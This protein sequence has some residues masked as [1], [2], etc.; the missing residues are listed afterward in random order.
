MGGN[1]GEC[2]APHD[3]T[4]RDDT[5]LASRLTTVP[6]ILALL[7]LQVHATPDRCTKNIVTR[8]VFATESAFTKPLLLIASANRMGH[9]LNPSR[10]SASRL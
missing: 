1:D 5:R 7:V 3:T 4:Q 8:S 6:S 10:T 2:M 9:F